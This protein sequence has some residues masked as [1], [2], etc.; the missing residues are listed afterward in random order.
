MIKK[1]IILVIMVLGI[2]TA[3]ADMDME[4]Y[5]DSGGGDITITT[6]PNSGDGETTYILDGKNFDQEINRLD[7]ADI[8]DGIG[9]YF[10]KIYSIFME[11]TNPNSGVWNIVGYNS[12]DSQGLKLRM[13][14]DNYFVPRTEVI[15][16][17]NNKE[18]EINQLRL[19]IMAIQELIPEEDLCQARINVVKKL[20]LTSVACGDTVYYNHIEG[21]GLIGLAEIIPKEVVIEEEPKPEEEFDEI[22][23]KVLDVWEKMCLKGLNKFCNILANYYARRDEF[24]KNQTEE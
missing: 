22:D 13:V 6:N 20:N 4:L 18:A 24:M 12:L 14:L 1:Y 8:H 2:G 3:M 7:K 10:Y 17:I 5:A 23:Y 16:M 15:E 19:E 11:E 9:Y 21:D